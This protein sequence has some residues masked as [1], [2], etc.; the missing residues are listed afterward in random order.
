M[1]IY[2]MCLLEAINTLELSGWTSVGAA[3]EPLVTALR[4]TVIG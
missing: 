4:H 3:T 1:H 2:V